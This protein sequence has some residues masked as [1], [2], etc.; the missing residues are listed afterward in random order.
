M[1]YIRL[2]RLSISNWRQAGTWAVISAL[3]K[4]PCAGTR[5]CSNSWTI[6]KSWNPGSCS[7][8]SSAKVIV[9]AAEQEPHFRVIRCT[10]PRFGFQ[11][12]RPVLNSLME[13]IT[14]VVTCLHQTRRRE[15]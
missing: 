4:R 13:A 2:Q 12:L 11:T 5:R 15:E 10:R 14:S 1:P 9:P 3:N 6:T 8:K 7:T